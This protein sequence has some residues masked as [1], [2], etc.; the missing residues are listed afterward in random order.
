[1]N[2]SGT[3]T[4]DFEKW[5]KFEID[6]YIKGYLGISSAIS[7]MDTV[8]QF[9]KSTSSRLFAISKLAEAGHYNYFDCIIDYTYHIK[10]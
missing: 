8:A 2:L 10:N 6:Q 4:T 7:G 9:G 3:D 5:N 1:M